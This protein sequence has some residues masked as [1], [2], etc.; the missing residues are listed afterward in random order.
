MA[1]VLLL[2]DDQATYGYE[3]RRQLAWH[4]LSTDPASLYRLL[5]QLERDGLLESRW[6]RP[7]GG[8]RRRLYRL[9]PDGRRNLDEIAGLIDD[10]RDVHDRFLRTYHRALKRRLA[11]ADRDRE[12]PAT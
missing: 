8:P 2:L 3:L 1:W 12:P 4:H 5:R 6:M 10:L 9:T 7:A 11:A